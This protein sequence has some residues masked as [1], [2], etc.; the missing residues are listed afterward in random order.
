MSEKY[1][2]FATVAPA[3]PMPFQAGDIL[4]VTRLGVSY[5]IHP[6]DLRL[7]VNGPTVYIVPTTGNT[8]TAVAGQGAFE[9]VPAGTLA[10]LAMVLP[11]TPDDDQ[12]FTASTT[13]DLTALTVTAPGGASVIGGGPSTL[14]ANG[15]TSWRFRL[16]DLTWYP[17]F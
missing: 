13:H 3:L 16:A 7:A 5:Q 11:P 6:A 2:L 8:I 12:I 10:T 4:V 9:I 1:S 14:A 17:R 15:G